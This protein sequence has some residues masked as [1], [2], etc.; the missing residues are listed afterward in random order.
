MAKKRNS[1]SERSKC[2]GAR[3]KVHIS[4]DDIDKIGCTM[5]YICT[6][7]KEACDIYV[8]TRRLWAMDSHTKVLEDNRSKQRNEL[9]KKEVRRI[10]LNEDL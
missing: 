9:T 10:L 5:Y 3:V 2:C 7:C 1:S 6:K 8:A 4:S